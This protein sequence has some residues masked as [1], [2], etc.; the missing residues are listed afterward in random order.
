[1]GRS[2]TTAPPFFYTEA[3]DGRRRKD[4]AVWLGVNLFDTG[5]P[6]GDTLS[7]RLRRGGGLDPVENTGILKYR[8]ESGD[9]YRRLRGIRFA[10]D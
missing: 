5:A 6:D 9:E 4:Q 1:M 7:V 10:D 2:P 3:E 8:M